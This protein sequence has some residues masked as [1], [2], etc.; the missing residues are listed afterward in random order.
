VEDN[1]LTGQSK[2]SSSPVIMK[3]LLDPSEYTYFELSNG[4]R[5]VLVEKESTQA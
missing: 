2:T 4:L 5:V 3:P 1:V